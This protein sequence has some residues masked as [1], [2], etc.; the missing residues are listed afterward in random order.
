MSLLFTRIALG[1]P[2]R[3]RFVAR[4]VESLRT[5][6]QEDW[7]GRLVARPDNGLW[8][9]LLSGPR[10]DATEGWEMTP[11]GPDRA[12]YRC[13]LASEHQSAEG[14]RRMLR[15]L[16]W[17]RI[18][19]FVPDDGSLM[20]RQIE[21]ALWDV[22]T[23]S[24]LNGAEAHAAPW[25][26]ARGEMRYAVTVERTELGTTPELLYCGVVHGAAEATRELSGALGLQ[27]PAP[28]ASAAPL[29]FL[30]EENK[31]GDT[32]SVFLGLVSA[33]EMD[34]VTGDVA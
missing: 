11:I 15:A 13:R 28:A 7:L 18:V 2:E 34:V 29:S 16:L 25:P 12:Q 19:V 14:V 1:T 4:A 24:A 3:D 20:G 10:R 8:E 32:E 22:I 23:K 31:R 30:V 33:F 6:P 27:S 5:P 21:E 26:S 17:K 9:I